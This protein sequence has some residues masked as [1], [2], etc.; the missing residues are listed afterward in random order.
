MRCLEGEKMKTEGKPKLEIRT[1]S[2]IG[3][4]FP[5]TPTLSLGERENRTQSSGKSE[6][7]GCRTDIRKT[8]GLLSLFP[9]PKEEGQ[10]EGKRGVKLVEAESLELPQPNLAHQLRIS[11][12]RFRTFTWPCPS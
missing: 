3:K 5:L 1:C 6:S 8:K 11:D 7:E 4:R 12:F 10:G 9:F 2:L